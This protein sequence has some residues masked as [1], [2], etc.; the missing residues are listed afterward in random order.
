VRS[1]LASVFIVTCGAIL[2]VSSGACGARS[3]IQRETGHGG[4]GGASLDDGGEPDGAL[5]GGADADA[6]DGDAAP[7][8]PNGGPCSQPTDC[9]D[10][11]CN[12]DFTCGPVPCHEEF[13][14]CLEDSDCC[15]SSCTHIAPTLSF[16]YQCVEKGF[17]CSD[18]GVPCCTGYCDSI[19]R[20]WDQP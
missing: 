18:A 2:A 15:N 6:D 7:C 9:C 20:C 5:D 17:L 19:G 8:A 13:Y 4:S 11:E 12:V 1:L 14:F 10:N 3:A 16:C